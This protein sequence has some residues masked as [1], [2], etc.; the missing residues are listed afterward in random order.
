MESLD[1]E[2]YNRLL[3]YAH[4][5]LQNKKD[6]VTSKYDLVHEVWDFVATDFNA[7]IKEFRGAY[8]KIKSKE[9]SCS[10]FID[11]SFSDRGATLKSRN[12]TCY[13]TCKRCG[14]DCLGKNCLPCIAAFMRKHRQRPEIKE[15]HKAWYRQ[16]WEKNKDIIRQRKKE[17]AKENRI[18]IN[19]YM[20]E[21]RKKQKL[22]PKYL[23]AASRRVLKHYYKKKAMRLAQSPQSQIA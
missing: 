13:Q 17:Y 6:F 1:T 15:H 19:E 14:S 11:A 12:I 10:P 9:F 16:Y 4:G 18:Q 8:S 3:R 7:I 5:F 23:A 22:D 20:K 2:L 21:Y